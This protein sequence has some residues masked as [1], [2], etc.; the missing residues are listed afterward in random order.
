MCQ[1]TNITM[2]RHQ[3]P[4][5]RKNTRCAVHATLMSAGGASAS[6]MSPGASAAAEHARAARGASPA[7]EAA[8]QRAQGSRAVPY[9]PPDFHR[10]AYRAARRWQATRRAPPTKTRAPGTHLLVGLYR[11]ALHTAC[12]GRTARRPARSG[13]AA[14]Q[15]AMDPTARHRA[16]LRK[17]LFSDGKDIRCASQLFN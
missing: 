6:A 13:R 15:S 2:N 7:T 14:P 16:S 5:G 17:G 1:P 4:S 10:Q 3:A 9:A 12:H 8:E 11:F